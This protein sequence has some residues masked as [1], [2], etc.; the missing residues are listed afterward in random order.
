VIANG[1]IAGG[2]ADNPDGIGTAFNLYVLESKEM[3]DTSGESSFFVWHGA[4][5]APGV[6]VFAR[7]VA[8]LADDLRYLDDTG[9][10]TVPA[11][12]YTVDIAPA[13]GDVIASFTAPLSGLDGQA[14]GVLASGFLDPAANNGGEAFGLLA[15][16]ADGTTLMLPA[17]D[18]PEPEPVFARAQIIHNVQELLFQKEKQIM[19]GLEA[20]LEK[21]S[22]MHR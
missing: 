17:A 2:F 19:P 21:L 16:L 8:Q 7:D 10:I 1:L 6:D 9:Y 14:L 11:A 20:W 18:L 22:E 12:D 13:G 5:D 15:V 4:T 3:H